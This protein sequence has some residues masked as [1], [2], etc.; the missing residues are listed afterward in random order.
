MKNELFELAVMASTK[1]PPKNVI[2]TKTEHRVHGALKYFFQPNDQ[3]HEVRVERFIC[4]ATDS[5]LHEITEIQTKGFGLLRKKLDKLLQSHPVNLIYPIIEEKRIISIYSESG[6]A[7]V[8]KSPKRTTLYDTVSELSAIHSYLPHPN[9]HIKAVYLK[10][11]ETRVF[12]GEK[13]ARKP[14]QKPISVEK[15]PTELIKTE[16]IIYPDFYLSFLKNISNGQ[17]TSNDFAR[18]NGISVA[19]A[20]YLLYLL[21]ELGTVLRTGKRNKAYIYVRAY[22]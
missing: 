12:S 10:I 16:D 19:E 17:F 22:T 1:I 15:V 4:D 20:R 9:L 8:R 3:Y 14:F 13:S 6:E 11:D 7:T 2:G 18:A 5:D 21:T